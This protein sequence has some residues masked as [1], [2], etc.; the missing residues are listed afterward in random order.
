MK[1]SQ[2]SFLL[3][4]IILWLPIAGAVTAFFPDCAHQN[5]AG[6]GPNAS[7]RF[8]ANNGLHKMDHQQLMDDRMAT[9]QPCEVNTLCHVS[10]STLISTALSTYSPVNNSSIRQ[11]ENINAA[12]FIPDL[13]QHP[14]RVYSCSTQH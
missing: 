6:Q 14:P 11:S 9:N 2:C 1:F 13:P 7:I 12:S 10:C 4:L 3:I 5:N 8:I